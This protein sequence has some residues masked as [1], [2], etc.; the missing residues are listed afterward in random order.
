[1]GHGH[2]KACFLLVAAG[3]FCDREGRVELEAAGEVQACFDDV[4]AA[5][6]ADDFQGLAYGHPVVQAEVAGEI[7]DLGLDAGG[8]VGAIEV[9]DSG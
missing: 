3:H 4:A 8:F 1:M 9:E 7:A 6:L 2:D 5:D